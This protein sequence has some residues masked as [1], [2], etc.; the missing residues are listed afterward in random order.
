MSSQELGAVVFAGGYLTL[1]VIAVRAL[2]IRRVLWVIGLIVFFAVAVAF[3]S[4]GVITGTR[5]P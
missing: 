3:R 2:G 4:L 1:A 5:R